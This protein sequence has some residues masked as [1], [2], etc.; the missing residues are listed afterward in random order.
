MEIPLEIA[1]RDVEP[2]RGLEA[3]I[4]EKT[5]RLERYFDRITGCRVLLEAAHHRHRK[6]NL[7]HV[8]ID[9]TVPGREIVVRRDPPEAH[10]HEEIGVAVRD[11]FKAA[12]RQLQ[13]YAR[14]RRGQTKVHEEPPRGRVL[15]VF[16]EEGYGF[17]G[18]PDGREVYFHA[19][20]VLGGA[21]GRL[22]VGEEVRFVEE[23]GEK[24]AQATSVRRVASRRRAV[25]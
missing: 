16:P 8:R 15:R 22:R 12:R 7:Y 17:L 5:N 10:G 2:P 18:T 20:A 1:Y 24:G 4:R 21:F 9:I 14:E 25:R 3:R 6:G 11:A 13:D 19:N 23:A